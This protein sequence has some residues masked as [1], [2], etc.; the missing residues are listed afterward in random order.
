MERQVRVIGL[1]K[2]LCIPL[3][4]I[5]FYGTVNSFGPF[6]ARLLS[7]AAMA[8]FFLLMRNEQHRL[9]GETIAGDIRD[10]IQEV[11]NVESFVEIRRVKSGI[12]A[13]VY[14]VNAREKAVFVQRAITRKLEECSMKKYLWVMQLTDMPAGVSLEETQQKLNEKLMEELRRRH[15]GE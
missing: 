5:M 10:A 2:W 8:G 6:A 15:K 12:L 13:R 9:I 1:A 14:L 4:C 11:G 3:G 7:L